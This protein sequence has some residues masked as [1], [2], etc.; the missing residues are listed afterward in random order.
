MIQQI[1]HSNL[2]QEIKLEKLM[3]QKQS[4]I[5]VILDLKCS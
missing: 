2:E 1:N 4:M 5:T 3:K